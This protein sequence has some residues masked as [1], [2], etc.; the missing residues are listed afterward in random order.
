MYE[1]LVPL[2][3]LCCCCSILILAAEKIPMTCSV[4]PFVVY[5]V[6]QNARRSIQRVRVTHTHIQ[7]MISRDVREVESRVP[8]SIINGNF[9]YD[10]VTF[11]PGRRWRQI[12]NFIS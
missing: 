1:Y 11:G 2:L 12:A 4:C 6:V 10:D 5:F 3:C 8:S 9:T 7:K